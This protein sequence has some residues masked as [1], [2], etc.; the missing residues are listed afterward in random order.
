MRY[1]PQF[2]SE[3]VEG[4][5]CLSPLLQVFSATFTWMCLFYATAFL[6]TRIGQIA[7]TSCSMLWFP[8]VK[9]PPLVSQVCGE[10]L[11]FCFV[12]CQCHAGHF[13]PAVLFSPYQLHEWKLKILQHFLRNQTFTNPLMKVEFFHG[14]FNFLLDFFHHMNMWKWKKHRFVERDHSI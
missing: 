9:C 10:C 2:Q 7:S 11:A 1:R 8:S 13:M 12:T 3:M 6:N 4:Q 14:C 5:F